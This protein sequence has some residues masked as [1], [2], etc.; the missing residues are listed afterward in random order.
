MKNLVALQIFAAVGKFKSFTKAS[1]H[2]GLTKSTVSRQIQ[3]LERDLDVK[4][5]K[6][7]PRHFALTDEGSV[8][9]KRAE[10]IL[11][12]TE[13]ALD[14]V[15]QIQTSLRGK[16][17]ISTTADL[18]L[19]YLADPLSNFSINHPEIEFVIE[20]TPDRIDLIKD[21]IDMAIRAGHPKDSGLYGKKIDEVQK[22]FFASPFYLERNGR[23]KNLLDFKNH[24]V[25]ATDKVN[26]QNLTITPSIKAK[27]MTLIKQLTL[28][29]AGI[30]LMPEKLAL[31]EIKAGTL[32]HVLP[33]LK[34]PKTPIFLLYP[35]KNMPKRISM[36]I[37][38]IQ[39]SIKK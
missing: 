12:Q 1:E 18:S 21:D 11:S 3:C 14:E 30:G 13:Q 29:G 28:N 34:L 8:L 16:I 10:S 31:A 5:I 9:L 20:I 22:N 35:N 17:S 6:R 33:S 26:L 7:D 38:A 2:L 24:N 36:F 25:I 15:T 19:Q 39:N 4:L 32:I 23:P 37:Q 27:N